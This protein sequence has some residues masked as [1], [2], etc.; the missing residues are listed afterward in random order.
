M[1]KHVIRKR[2][3]TNVVK[4]TAKLLIC[5]PKKIAPDYRAL[6]I[7]LSSAPLEGKIGAMKV[8][9]DRQE[10]EALARGERVSHDRERLVRFDDLL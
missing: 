6:S 2:T 4:K 10:R 5:L 9:R 7:S 8:E 3:N 1:F